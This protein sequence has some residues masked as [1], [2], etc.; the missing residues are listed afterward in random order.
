MAPGLLP[1][2]RFSREPSRHT[3]LPLFEV[4]L[5][6]KLTGRQQ[7]AA[8]L[9][10]EDQLSDTAIAEEVGIS[11]RALVKWKNQPAFTVRV[12]E[13][14]TELG[15]IAMQSAITRRE[16]RIGVLNQMHSKVLRVMEERAVDPEMANVPGGDTG[17]LVKRSIVSGGKLI[18]NDYAV[19]VAL[20]AELRAIFEQA[21][22]EL[23]QRTQKHEVTNVLTVEVIDS[24]LSEADD[25]E[26]EQLVGRGERRELRANS[27]SRMISSGS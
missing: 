11:R 7:K 4:N 9:L 8:A 17:L 15:R 2:F 3:R 16:Y 20:L 21:A 19:D 1:A 5:M 10:A 13:I 18:A 6:K 27:S 22:Q 24:W 12:Q 26:L 23:G 25:E 14:Q